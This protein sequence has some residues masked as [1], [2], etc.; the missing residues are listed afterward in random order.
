MEARAGLSK[1]T[2]EEKLMIFERR[3][4]ITIY[5]PTCQ[6]GVWTIKCNDEQYSLY[7][8]PDIERE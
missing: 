3:I 4:M 8:D 5:G 1:K 2:D 6:N 7:K